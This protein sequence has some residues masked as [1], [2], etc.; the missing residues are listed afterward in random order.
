MPKIPYSSQDTGALPHNDG[1]AR[2]NPSYW[3]SKFRKAR[4]C[5]LRMSAK[6]LTCMVSLDQCLAK[7]WSLLDNLSGGQ[8]Y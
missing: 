5:E 2:G 4:R 1:E 8:T 7:L 3:K 6:H